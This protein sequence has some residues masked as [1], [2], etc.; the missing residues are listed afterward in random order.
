MKACAG[1]MVKKLEERRGFLAQLIEGYRSKIIEWCLIGIELVMQP[2][3]YIAKKFSQFLKLLG[4]FVQKH[5][6][7]ADKLPIKMQ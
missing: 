3:L 5:I 4:N 6:M 7:S 2:F 1:E